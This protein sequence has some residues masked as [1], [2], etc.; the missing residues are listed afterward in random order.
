ML[1]YDFMIAI[2]IATILIVIL[3]IISGLSLKDF[4]VYE[5]SGSYEVV[6]IGYSWPAFFFGWIWAFIKRLWFAGV[7]YLIII[8]S[9]AIAVY[10]LIGNHKPEVK[11]IMSI[12]DLSVSLIF[13]FLGNTWI[14]NRLKINGFRFVGTVTAKNVDKAKI[15]CAQGEFNRQEQDAETFGSKSAETVPVPSLPDGTAWSISGLS[16][17]LAGKAVDLE[18]GSLI[19]GRDPNQSNLIIQSNQGIS[20][21]HCIIRIDDDSKN[22]LIE[23]C[24]SKNGTFLANGTRLEVGR[25]YPLKNGDRFYIVEPDISFEIRCK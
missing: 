18:D 24:G 6:K 21:K 22:I 25:P 12:I 4:A 7:T 19:I 13:G 1:G 23:D 8:I 16:G 14:E 9:S 10:M 17:P 5:Y 20:R 2:L 11:I 3:A 15:L